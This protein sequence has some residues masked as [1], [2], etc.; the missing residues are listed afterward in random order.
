MSISRRKNKIIAIATQS[1][2]AAILIIVVSNMSTTP[3]SATTIATTPLSQSGSDNNTG[4]TSSGLMSGLNF[5]EFSGFNNSDSS[6]DFD[7]SLLSSFMT[8]VN[9]TYVNPNIG[10]QIDLPTGWKGNEINFLINSVF[11]APEEINLLELEGEEA[12]QN[13]PTLMTVVGIDEE[14]LDMIEGFSELATLGEGGEIGEEDALLQRSEP[15]DTTITPLGNNTLSCTFS[16][17]SFVTING[18]NAEERMSE[19]IDKE[20]GEGMS[21]QTKSYTFATQNNSLIVVG[22]YGNSTITY[23][24]YLPL[25]EES[26]RTINITQPADIATSE[27]YNRYKELVH[28][29]LSNQTTL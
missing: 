13:L 20:G 4:V 16:Q 14:T 6:E 27:I 19:C 15:L 10:F 3:I 8:D 22:F 25:F 2:L 24:Q 11:A 28:T 5:S 1:I 23:N 9:G 12:F 21:L 29:Q 26:V 18:I 7:S 17:P